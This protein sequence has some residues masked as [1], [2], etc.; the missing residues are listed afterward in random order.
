[1]TISSSRTRELDIDTIVV[2]AFQMAGL[3]SSEQSASSV[4]SGQGQMAR[5]FLELL[6]DSLQAYGAIVRTTVFYDLDVTAND[7]Q[8]NLD[9][10]TLDVL[11]AAMWVADGGDAQT[12]VLPMSREEYQLIGNKDASGSPTRFF[13]DRTASMTLFMWPV[14]DENG[15][16]T[17]QQHRLLADCDDGSKTVDLERHWV[18]SLVL[19]LASDLAMAS[20]LPE[21]RVSMLRGQYEREVEKARGFS[22][23]SLPTRMVLNH[24][25]GWRR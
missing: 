12:A 9:S 1:M 25:T 14:P 21:E 5:D 10:S 4:T 20:S 7:G 22:L 23:P 19:G 11:G 13:L 6:V 17:L 16:L 8:Y 2:R 18:R 15:T 3:L 24:P